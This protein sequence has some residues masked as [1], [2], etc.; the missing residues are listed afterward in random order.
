MNL[1]TVIEKN[2]GHVVPKELLELALKAHPRVSGFAARPKLDGKDVID[3]EFCEKTTTIDNLVKL[4]ANTKDMPM[5]LFFSDGKG[6]FDVKKDIQPFVLKDGDL[7]VIAYCV[8]GDFGKFSVA[9]GT[10]SDEGNLSE[11]LIEPLLIEAMENAGGDM[12]KFIAKLHSPLFKTTLEAAIGHRGVFSFLPINGDIVSLFDKNDLGGTFDWGKTSMLHGYG[13]KPVEKPSIVEQAVTTGRKFF[14][15]MLN[16]DKKDETKVDDNG[17]HHLPG[18]APSPQAPHPDADKDKAPITS[19]ETD[20]AASRVG[21][22]F[23]K[24]PSKLEKG[25]RNFWLRLFNNNELPKDHQSKECGLWVAP[26]YV[27]LAKRDVSKSHELKS[28]EKEM[29]TAKTLIKPVDFREANAEADKIT[30]KPPTPVSDFIPDMNADETSAAMALVL[31][32]AEK[33]ASKAPSPIDI[34][35]MEEAWP[36]FSKKVGIPLTDILFWTP[37][38][39]MKFDKKA[40]LMLVNEF[41]AEFRKGV[42]LASLIG[43][44]KK[45]TE[46]HVEAKTILAPE[47][48]VASGGRRFFS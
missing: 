43:T 36:K 39:L 40:L 1:S 42:D 19:P 24:P 21:R 28:I 46:K 18:S 26:E 48:K 38:Q 9:G 35:R 29:K 41:K 10:R 6:T 11:K 2:A 27:E 47:P 7:N 30:A 31:S 33:D 44:A 14:G 20:T 22:V 32:F 16:G 23:L 13:V 37:D 25:G 4:M 5:L 15:S 34:Q 45:E 8:E 12:G 17:I 3:Y